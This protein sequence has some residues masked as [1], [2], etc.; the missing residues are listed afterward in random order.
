ETALFSPDLEAGNKIAAQRE[1]AQVSD[2]EDQLVKLRKAYQKAL[3]SIIKGEALEA[4]LDYMG[5]VLARLQKLSGK[6]QIGQL[7]WISGAMLDGLL[8]GSVELSK[9]VNSL[10]GAVDRQLKEMV[11][12]P[13]KVLAGSVSKE[14]AKNILY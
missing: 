6:S 1:E 7:W 13:K 11:D 8:N 10:L 9:S 14:L 5:K 12:D 3:I 2:L 4:N